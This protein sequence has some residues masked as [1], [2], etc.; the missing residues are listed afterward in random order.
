MQ[1]GRTI[2]NADNGSQHSEQPLVHVL[3]LRVSTCKV[4]PGAWSAT[5][6]QHMCCCSVHHAPDAVVQG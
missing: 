5:Y 4:V 3:T 1:W 6:V 2:G